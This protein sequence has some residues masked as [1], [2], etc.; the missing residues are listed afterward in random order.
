MFGPREARAWFQAD[1]DPNISNHVLPVNMVF[2]GAAARSEVVVFT[3][4]PSQ[5]LQTLRRDAVDATQPSGRFDQWDRDAGITQQSWPDGVT[6]QWPSPTMPCIGGAC[7]DPSTVPVTHRL[8]LGE[9]FPSPFQPPQ[10]PGLLPMGK[11]SVKAAAVYDHGAC[12]REVSLQEQ[13]DRQLTQLPAL[14]HGAD[15]PVHG[16]YTIRIASFLDHVTGDPLSLT[17]GYILAVRLFADVVD[18]APTFDLNLAVEF[19]IRR[20]ASGL[21]VAE[22][23]VLNAAP[24]LFNVAAA[25]LEKEFND[26]VATQQHQDLFPPN[27]DLDADGIPESHLLAGD[28]VCDPLAA[29]P[30][31]NVRIAASAIAASGAESLGLSAADRDQVAL[32]AGERSNWSCRP[33]T[34]SYTV[35]G[36]TVT[37]DRRR[38]MYF[39]PAKRVNAFPDSFESVFFDGTEPENPAFAIWAMLNNDGVIA[40]IGD[41]RRALCNFLPVPLPGAT[42]RSFASAFDTAVGF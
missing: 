39:V 30:C 20:L 8:L 24:I 21:I 22:R 17:G 37:V 10:G 3:L 1:L 42:Q 36:E 29:D 12:S 13:F 18:P 40:S 2:M 38:C 15:I 31:T 5:H 16:L 25:F 11:G 28:T 4:D 27:L 33:V 26:R 9:F 14:I 6:L 34:D 7:I 19:R 41:R 35:S 23:T 32:T